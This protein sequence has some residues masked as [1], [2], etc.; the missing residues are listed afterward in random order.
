[1]S[2]AVFVADER[3]YSLT[4]YRYVRS[5]YDFMF[6]QLIKE[7]LDEKSSTEIELAR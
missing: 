3:S 4:L 6:Q 2:E 7:R 1:M 5:I